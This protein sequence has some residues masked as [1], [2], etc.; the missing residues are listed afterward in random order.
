MSLCSLVYVS[1]ATNEMSDEALKSLLKVAR[2]N[3]ELKGITGML[4]YREGLFIQALEGE[5][6]SVVDLF[7]KIKNDERHYNVLLIHQEPI[8]KRDF[9]QWTMGFAAPNF[10]ALMQT[11]GFTDFM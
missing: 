6:S 9:S 7:E 10:D 8:E 2:I 4:L 3:N 5:E 1:I 11:E